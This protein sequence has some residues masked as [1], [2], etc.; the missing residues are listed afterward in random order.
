VSSYCVLQKVASTLRRKEE[1]CV[2]AHSRLYRAYTRLANL[3]HISGFIVVVFHS[4]RYLW[5]S[6]C[7]CAFQRPPCT[8]SSTVNGDPLVSATCLCCT[9]M[10][11]KNYFLIFER[12]ST[13]RCRGTLCCSHQSVLLFICHLSDIEEQD[14]ILQYTSIA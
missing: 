11:N 10:R 4:V 8:F 14:A 2:C 7:G 6:R 1:S 12:S 13:L 9:A 5:S 3:Y